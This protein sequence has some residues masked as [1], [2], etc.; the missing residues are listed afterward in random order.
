MRQ[1]QELFGI[2]FDKKIEK[3]KKQVLIIAILILGQIH[4][5][6]GI[7]TTTPHASAK[8]EVN[9][10]NKGFL[11]PRV[12]LTSKTDAT[13]IPSPAEGLLVY[14][15]GNNSGLVAGYYYWNGANWAT[16]A[17]AIA[18]GY[19]VAASEMQKIY[20]GVGNATTINSTGVTFTVPTS[21]T[22]LFDFSCSGTNTNGTLTMNFYVRDGATILKSDMQTSYSNNVHAE[23][24]GKIEVNLVIGKT[25]NVL[26]NTSSGSIYSNDYCRVYMKQMSG[27][28]PVNQHMAEQNFQLNNNYLSNDGD[29]EGIRIDNSGKVGIGTTTPGTSLHIQNG[30][31]FG[32]DPSSTNSPGLYIYNTNNASTTA[33]STAVIRTNGSGG[34]NPYLTFDING[35]R[36]Y[37]IGIDNADNDKL[38]FHSNWNLNNSVTPAMTITNENRI[39]IGTTNPSAPLHVASS[40][41]QTVGAYGYLA[42]NGNTGYNGVSQ[43]INYSIQTDE[44]IRAPEFNAMSDR[45][46]KTDIFKL[47]TKK[48]LEELN[49]FNVVNYSY[50]D[51]LL[52]G[53]K[54]KTGLIAQEVEQVNSKFVNQSEEFIPSVY[55][56]AKSVVLINDI[57]QV[58]TDAPHG[59]EKGDMVKVFA[60]GKKEII[61]TIEEIKSPHE[62]SVKGWD[63][64]INHMFVYGKKVTDFR[65]IDFD[66]ITALSVGAIQ[67]LSK[68]V[69][70]LKLEK[71]FLNKRIS[72]EVQKKQLEFEKRL[73]QL[74]TKFKKKKK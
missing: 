17:T 65:A 34:G 11:P 12:T 72:N 14:N 47:D 58:T 46:I 56:L 29:N 52:N 62:F 37:S 18:A 5:Q 7:G 51:K 41:T 64:S 27:N 55:A 10:T 68:Q 40:V 71:E 31:T 61:L 57:L 44:R 73:L 4:A 54:H 32:T 25:Y 8:L 30:N 33:H 48:Q 35:I 23:Y 2:G 9:A 45:R 21:G 50:I 67:E 3:M 43:T 28:L 6:T 19:A 39:G 70:K 74:E 24:N 38:K 20:D 16:I 59:F 36:G 49:K 42:W 13:T 66:Q 22:Y 69:E 15:T 60:E 26:V 53:N 63:A 1:I